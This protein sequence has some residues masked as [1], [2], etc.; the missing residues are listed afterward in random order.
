MVSSPAGAVV[1][2]THRGWLRHLLLA[3]SLVVVTLSVVGMHQLS[4]GHDIATG[5]SSSHAHPDTTAHADSSA[6]TSSLVTDT[7]MAGHSGGGHRSNALDP[8]GAGGKGN[9]CSSCDDHQM[10]FGSCLLALTLLVIS[11]MLIPPRARHLPPFLLPRLVPAAVGPA[12]GRLVPA[13][14]LTELSLRR[15]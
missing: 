13:L 8:N 6:L 7:D 12:V 1:H 5:P 14:S 3:L 10:A 9:A 2:R 11:W 15:T 4:M